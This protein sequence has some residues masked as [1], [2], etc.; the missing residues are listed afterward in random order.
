MRL[1]FVFGAVIA[2]AWL[3]SFLSSA[4]AAPCLMVTL[5]GT[6]GGLP[7][8]AISIGVR[9]TDAITRPCAPS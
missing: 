3:A 9:W 8:A 2:A 6:Q 1:I 7:A 5:T 4:H